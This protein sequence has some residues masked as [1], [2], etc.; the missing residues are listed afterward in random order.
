MSK[1]SLLTAAK[2]LEESGLFANVLVL[3]YEETKDTVYFEAIK[4][5][6]QR[7]LARYNEV[8][9]DIYVYEEGFRYE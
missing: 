3:A 8:T 2:A 6:G 5:D 9:K 4:E 7:V 1:Q